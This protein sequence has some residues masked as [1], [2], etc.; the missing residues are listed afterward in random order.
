MIISHKHQFIFIKPRKV[1]GTSV[2][3]ALSKFCG[4]DDIITPNIKSSEADAEDYQ[5]F[6]RNHHGFFNHMSAELI[7]KKIGKKIWKKYFKFAIVRNPYD[8]VVSRYFWNKKNI[9][10]RAKPGAV[11]R[12]IGQ[13]PL[14]GH[15]YKK[16]IFS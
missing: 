10:P 8:M 3:V 7:A 9:T 14:A 12:E 6:A 2:E 11:W 1:A 4:L 13:E 16:F 15:L 5:D